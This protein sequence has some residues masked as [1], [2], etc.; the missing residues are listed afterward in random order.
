MKQMIL[1][2]INQESQLSQG[3]EPNQGVPL[4]SQGTGDGAEFLQKLLSED[5]VTSVSSVSNINFPDSTKTT[6][7]DAILA[8]LDSIGASYKSAVEKTHNLLDGPPG[9]LD[10]QVLLQL[11]IDMSA[12][13]LQVE[14]VGKGVSKAVQHFDQLTKLQ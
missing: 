2:M 13:S 4:P 6:M 14:L 5:S 12:V 8:R 9:K 3:L 11:E 10:L 7:G 1:A